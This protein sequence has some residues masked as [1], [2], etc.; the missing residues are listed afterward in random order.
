MCRLRVP[1][2]PGSTR[3]TAGGAAPGPCAR[4]GVLGAPPSLEP[5]GSQRSGSPW[6][7]SF[8]MEM[9]P[10][11][12]NPSHHTQQTQTPGQASPNLTWPSRFLSIRQGSAQGTSSEGSSLIAPKAAS[13]LSSPPD[14]G[15]S[16]VRDRV[17]ISLAC[18]RQSWQTPSHPGS[19]A[20]GHRA[21]PGAHVTVLRRPW[22]PGLGWAVRGSQFDRGG[23][24]D[25]RSWPHRLLTLP[26]Y[27]AAGTMPVGGR[28]VVGLVTWSSS[29]TLGGGEAPGVTRTAPAQ[30]EP[31]QALQVA[32][33]RRPPPS[34]QVPWGPG[35]ALGSCAGP[36]ERDAGQGGAHARRP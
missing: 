23:S 22:L 10:T 21:G 24:G 20:R 27:Q 28:H 14:G 16:R 7:R 8:E 17:W 18:G 29:E 19:R 9:K 11:Y 6:E 15:G 2:G 32:R 36:P 35:A 13:P 1:Q 33:R 12:K 30:C 31:P 25:Q 34:T 5:L 4:A 3:C 26:F